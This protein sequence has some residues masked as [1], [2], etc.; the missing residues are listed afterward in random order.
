MIT[1]ID[2]KIIAVCS[3]GIND[4]YNSAFLSTLYN[5]A[6]EYHFKLLYFTSFSDLYEDTK[7]NLGEAT[8]FQLIDYDIIDG[9][10]ILSETLKNHTYLDRLVANAQLH[11][12]PIVS[13]D[14]YIKGC[15]S[16]S[17]DYDTAMEQLCRH[18]IEEHKF[19]KINFVAGIEGNDFSENR[20]SIFKRVMAENNLEVEE[21]RIGYGGFW[22]GPTNE[23]MD[24]FL[25][26]DLPTPEAI[27]CS[28]DSMAVVVYERLVA[29]GYRVP[30]DISLSGF[31]GIE[32]ALAHV[33]TITTAK[34]DHENVI[35]TAYSILT[36]IFEGKEV[37]DQ[38]FMPSRIIYG[39]SCN[40]QKC[41]TRNSANTLTRTL[42]GRMDSRNCT[43]IQRL[44]M[45]ADLTDNN[46]YDDLIENMK[47]YVLHVPSPS[48]RIC[49]VDN[50]IDTA[51]RIDALLD[52]KN[53]AYY[54]CYSNKM[55]L[56][57]A[58]DDDVFSDRRV[59]FPTNRLL[60]DLPELLKK[61]SNI[62]FFPLHVLDTMIGY[63]AYVYIPDW[64]DDFF[65]LYMFANNVS[66]ACE[67]TKSR[68][69]QQLIIRSLEE[70]YIRDAMTGLYNRRGFYKEITP[71]YEMCVNKKRQLMVASVDLNG[72][73]PINDNYG[74]AE[75]DNAI[76]TV[77][78]ALLEISDH[79]EICARFGGDEYVV[80]CVV[81]DGD[82]FS[83]VYQQRFEEYL[84]NY[85]AT[86]CNPYEVSASFGVVTCTP[87]E[88]K[89][90][91]QCIKEADDKMYAIKEK[92]HLCRSRQ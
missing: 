90:L 10:I 75:G 67:S 92:H 23:V 86:A 36:D 39:E 52:V 89:T 91:D 16:I 85:N 74:H 30:E 78:N 1:G 87:S 61:N 79:N 55:L 40:C 9:M 26:S 42:C 72:L 7:H 4:E 24:R 50:F 83:K 41:T 37:E 32:E 44:Q 57:L 69:H 62:M 20:L 47:E 21:E 51:Y 5:H 19:T 88:G 66:N 80:A 6:E 53:S 59:T 27:I 82:A 64:A 18:F 84:E 48:A 28:N 68:V 2:E 13:I 3:A 25:A 14:R 73:K 65:S 29:A 46:T 63:F 77:A 17:F 70:K 22:E 31:D 15:Y 71:L 49:C 58:R 8:I 76:I 81:D 56:F 60:P 12:I 11:N 43:I 54:A 35:I 45:A 34:H 33:P 38:H